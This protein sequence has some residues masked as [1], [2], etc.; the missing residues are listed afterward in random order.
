VLDL[1]A[2]SLKAVTPQFSG[3]GRQGDPG[4]LVA[5][6]ARAQ[7]WGWRSGIDWRTGVAQYCRWFTSLR[8]DPE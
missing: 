2:D 6:P 5:D 3:Y 8:K 7:G 4:R 1:V